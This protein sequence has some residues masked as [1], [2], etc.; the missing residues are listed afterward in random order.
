MK[1]WGLPAPR[2]S[3][4]RV[5]LGLVALAFA[6]LMLADMQISVQHPGDELR[7]LL[8]GFLRPDFLAISVSALIRTVAFAVLG[9][10]L[11]GSVGFLFSIVFARSRIVRITCAFLRSIHELFWALLLMQITGLSPLTGVLAIALPYAGVFGKV[12]AELNEE[13]DLSALR[14]LPSGTSTL[15]A[16]FYARLPVLAKP[17][18]D[19]TLYRLECG[20]RSTLVLGFIGLPTI[21]F[22]LDS[23]FKQGDYAQAG[24]LLM[25]FYA[26]IATRRLWARP[27]TVPF[28]L[29]GSF[30]SLP[31]GLN[32]GSAMAN[33]ARFFGHD[34]VPAPLRHGNLSSL[35]PWMDTAGWLWRIG[36]GQ[37]LPGLIHTLVLSQI[38][39][40]AMALMSLVLFPWVCLRFA[41]P[42]GRPLGRALLVVARSTPE[43]MLAYVLLMVFGPS[44]LPAILALT[45]HNGAVVGYL[46]GRQADAL[47]FRQD[48][49]SRRL[50]LYFYEVLPR[51]YGQFL[52]YILY[53]WE[54]ILRESA[55]F[56]ILGVTTLGY[57]VDAAISDLK[58]DVAFVLLLATA[59]LS[60][61]VDFGSRWLRAQLRI[62]D[63][64][65]RLSQERIAPHLEKAQFS[66]KA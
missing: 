20:L 64:P 2:L 32:G 45:L 58:L 66:W 16:Y 61:T 55:I 40:V 8:S 37:I 29:V 38:A 27:L 43:Y 51:L 9:V 23:Y 56:G 15:S 24:A 3:Y 7:R 10:G 4:L 34:I 30:F 52:A 46:M 65:R 47:V 31:A 26:L 11:G 18:A 22:D 50:D 12:F 35:S 19:Y 53:R 59:A 60:M 17:F 49:P 5:S 48:A 62:Q 33:L 41:G 1:I 36:K 44:M 63:F 21:G 57:Y 14:V 13:A 28:L 25:S 42:L 54:I 39:L 6:G